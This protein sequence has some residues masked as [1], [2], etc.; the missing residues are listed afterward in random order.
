[1][2][3]QPLRRLE[4]IEIRVVVEQ[5]AQLATAAVS[6]H[7]EPEILVDLAVRRL[8]VER[9]HDLRQR[10]GVGLLDRSPR[11]VDDCLERRCAF[12]VEL[13]ET[14]RF[15]RRDEAQRKLLLVRVAVHEA[16]EGGRERRRVRRRLR[17][18]NPSDA[19]PRL[20]VDSGRR[21][22]SVGRSSVAC[23]PPDSTR[24]ADAAADTS[25]ASLWTRNEKGCDLRR[26]AHTDADCI[27]SHRQYDETT[28][29]RDSSAL[30]ANGSSALRPVASAPPEG[31]ARV[32]APAGAQ[33]RWGPCGSAASERESSD[34]RPGV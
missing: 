29:A 3:E 1:M 22:R 26:S 13:Q 17:R 8:R 5:Q 23:G 20:P 21:G 25:I 10:A 34:S 12:E 28:V 7:R 32:H 4:L 15:V 11:L 14:R 19:R 24:S 30:R 18:S 27:A 33:R 31:R 9:E 2:P 6:L 16:C